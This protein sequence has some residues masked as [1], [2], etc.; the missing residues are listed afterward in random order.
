MLSRKA[1]H[2]LTKAGRIIKGSSE[3][4]QE[5]SE[6][7][8][9]A[10]LKIWEKQSVPREHVLRPWAGKADV[11]DTSWG[12]LFGKQGVAPPAW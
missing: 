6:L 3:E 7:L 9:S 12:C 1:L 2:F 5:F 8:G 4:E 10:S 11:R